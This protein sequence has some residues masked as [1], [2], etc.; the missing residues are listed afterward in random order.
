[1]R[2]E[3]RRFS[4]CSSTLWSRGTVPLGRHGCSVSVLSVTAA[5]PRRGD[6]GAML[7]VFRNILTVSSLF[8][9]KFFAMI[10]E[11]RSV[12]II[13]NNSDFLTD[14]RNTTGNYLFVKF[15]IF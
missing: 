3:S 11:F 13:K 8:E 10:P 15:R 6:R 5:L 9:T 1:M 4:H 12:K 2:H 14:Q 7:T